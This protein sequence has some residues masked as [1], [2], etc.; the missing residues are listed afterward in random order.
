MPH[1]ARKSVHGSQP[2][3]MGRPVFSRADVAKHASPGDMWIS[4]H[5]RVYD[6]SRLFAS[7]SH[8]GGNMALEKHA[9]RDCSQ[10]FDFH[11]PAGQRAFAA[12]QVGWL[13][14]PSDNPLLGMAIWALARRR[15][16]SAASRTVDGPQGV[17][18][19]VTSHGISVA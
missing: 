5:G 16:S 17:R 3:F 10:D 14:E 8:P 2:V 11:S 7:G 1:T 13:Q 6:I 4:A 18:G 9:G 19:H 15:N 12:Y